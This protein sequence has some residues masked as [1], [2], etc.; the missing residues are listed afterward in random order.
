[1]LKGDCDPESIVQRSI[2]PSAGDSGEQD[3]PGLI[4]AS[5]DSELDLAEVY[6]SG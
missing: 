1:M 3:K 2:L 5:S 6:S 4:T